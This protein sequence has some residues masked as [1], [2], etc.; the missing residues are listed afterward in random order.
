[1]PITKPTKKQE[2]VDYSLVKKS[3]LESIVNK[4]LIDKQILS[5]QEI[6]GKNNS[7]LL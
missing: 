5:S 3:E 1:M 4:N 7:V 2:F 6:Y